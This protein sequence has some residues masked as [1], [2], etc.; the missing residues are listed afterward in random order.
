MKEKALATRSCFRDL[1]I[2]PHLLRNYF[3]LKNYVISK[4]DVFHN[5]LD[6]H[7]LSIAL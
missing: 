5:L 4:G 6:Y 7:Q 2:N 1:E 3:F